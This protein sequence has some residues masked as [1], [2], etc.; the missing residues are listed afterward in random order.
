MAGRWLRNKVDG[1]I[2]GWDPILANHPKCEEVSEEVAFPEKFVKPETVKKVT[3]ARRK[4]G[5]A[6]D[7]STLDV[8]EDEGKGTENKALGAEAS[9]GMPG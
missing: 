3:K 8:S 2:Y 6:L 9:K 4:R 7:L 1:T 5:A